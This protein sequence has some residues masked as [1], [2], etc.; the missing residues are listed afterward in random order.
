MERFAKIICK[1][2]KPTYISNT[3]HLK[4]TFYHLLSDKKIKSIV[5]TFPNI[6]HLD[7]KESIS[8]GDKSLFIPL[9]VRN[10]IQ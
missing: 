2:H 9:N 10:F 6:I 7:F 8:F 4:I 1:K 3:T 5:E